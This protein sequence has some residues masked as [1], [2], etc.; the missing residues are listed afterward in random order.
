MSCPNSNAPIDIPNKSSEVCVEKCSLVFNYGQSSISIK[1]NGGFLSLGYD[2]STTNILYNTI[3]MEVNEI[4]IYTPSLHTYSGV[5]TEGEM[6]IS[7]SGFGENL[8]V[9]IPLK[10]ANAPLSGVGMLSTIIT[11]NAGKIANTG[12]STSM[13][14]TTWSLNSF[15]PNKKPF[16]SYTGSLPF[17]PCLGTYNYIV[18]NANDYYIPISA[19]AIQLLQGTDQKAGLIGKQQYSIHKGPSVFYN[20]YGAIN[21][22]FAGDDDDIYIECRPTGDEGQVLFKKNINNNS[23]KGTTNIPGSDIKPPSFE[24]IMN[25]PAS[26]ILIGIIATYAIFKVGEFGYKK[27]KG[28]N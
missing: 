21:S 27:L 3:K 1:N 9:C 26:Q 2:A 13:G 8:L 7:H 6:I 16:F 25:N 17:L 10:V 11:R 12:D 5:R 28:N 14:G 22:T 23:N 20:Q 4:R 24:E 19:Q 15:V 18:W